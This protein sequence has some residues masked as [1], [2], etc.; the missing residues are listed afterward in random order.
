MGWEV[1]PVADAVLEAELAVVPEARHVVDDKVDDIE[2]TIYTGALCDAAA[3]PGSGP[4]L[5]L[6]SAPPQ[7]LLEEH[8]MRFMDF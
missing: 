1:V 5:R 8:A 6:P 4:R 3:S 7:P 2:D